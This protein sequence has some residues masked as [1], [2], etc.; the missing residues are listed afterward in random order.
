MEN[1]KAIIMYDSNESATYR[2]DISGWVSSDGKFYGK[3]EHLA[4]W[5]GCTHTKCDCG[6][7]IPIRSYTKCESCR[8]K[9]SQDKY[10]S[11]PF[12]EYNGSPVFSSDGDTYFYE[13]EDIITYLEDN[14]LDEI[15]LLYTSPNY[16]DEI[17]TEYWSDILPEDGEIPDNIQKAM[18]ELNI[19]INKQGP[20]SYSPNK[21]RTKYTLTK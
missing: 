18:N 5:Q 17:S 15:N 12:K 13:E 4:R 6:E 8:N 9:I 21:I 10:N 2:T 1:T 7:T 20:I 14:E 3:D 16:L 11:L 19:L